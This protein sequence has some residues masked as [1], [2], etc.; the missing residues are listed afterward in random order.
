MMGI[1][2]KIPPFG[3]NDTSCLG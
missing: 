2:E 1:G 3:R